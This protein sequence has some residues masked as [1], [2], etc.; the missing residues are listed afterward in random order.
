MNKSDF[1]SKVAFFLSS[2]IK[3]GFFTAYLQL[4][5]VFAVVFALALLPLDFAFLVLAIIL[6]S[7]L[8]LARKI[9]R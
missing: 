6:H 2:A 3:G 1:N 5:V 4:L 7:F 8:R 9:H